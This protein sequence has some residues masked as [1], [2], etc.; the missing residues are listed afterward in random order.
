MDE[1]TLTEMPTE[2]TL[3][4][5]A[6]HERFVTPQMPVRMAGAIG[7]WPALSRWS[8]EALAARHGEFATFAYA[9]QR[10]RIS[11]DRK[12]GFRLVHL[13][14][15]E[16]V[17]RLSESSDAPSVYLRAPLSRLPAALMDD[18]EIPAYCRGRLALRHNLWFSGTG[19]VSQLHFDLPHNLVAQVHGHKRFV[20]FAP[21]ESPH[22]YP[23]P[24]LSSTPHLARVDPES[25]DYARFPLLRGARGFVCTLRPGDLL[26]IPSRWWHHARSLEASISTNF[27]WATPL[28]Y[29]FVR[30]SD[31]YKRARGLN[32]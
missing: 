16:Y 9:M 32:V 27:W 23:E 12:L 15:G 31:L 20:L 30:L 22:L 24:L 25:P 10:G 18:L 19:T 26:F 13:T 4:V 28:L 14:L 5:A 29:P 21:S 8:P 6:F 2:P 1:L 7:H 17:A 11:L 3:S